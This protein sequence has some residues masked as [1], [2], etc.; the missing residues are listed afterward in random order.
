MPRCQA[1]IQ[2]IDLSDI[3]KALAEKDLAFFIR[4]FWKYID[5]ADYVGGWHIQAICEHLEAVTSGDITRL[6]IT[7]P[8]RHMKS[9]AVSVAWPAWVWIQHPK[10][11]F[12]S[13]SYAQSL[14]I[15]DAVKS[16][17]I[18]D[19]QLY[20]EW[21]GD[22]YKLTSDQNTKIKYE[23]D[24]KG[25][26][27]ATSVG[28][29]T[30][31]DGGDIII[32]DDPHNV[33]DT[34][35]DLKRSSALEWWDTAMSTRLNDART[36]A[37]VI[38]AQRVHYNDLIGHIIESEQGGWI[39]LNLPAEYEP[40]RSCVTV[41]DWKDPRQTEGELLW[42]E[43]FGR[44][45]ID[46]L[47]EQLGTY[48]ASAQLQQ[49]PTPQGGG[50]IQASWFRY[51]KEKPFT[52]QSIQVWDTAFKAKETSDYSVCQTWLL[53]EFG[54]VL[55]DLYR[56]RLPYPDLKRMAT[57]LYNREHPDMVIIEDAASG[58]SLIQDFRN[59]TM[60]VMAVTPD[61]DKVSRAT[62]VTP[63]IESGKVYLREGAPWIPAFLDE[64]I[65]FPRGEFD[66][67]VDVMVHALTYLRRCNIGMDN[68]QG[69]ASIAAG[70]DW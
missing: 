29:S 57:S 21:Y 10:K 55:W 16:R 7:M 64:C 4:R 18:I 3:E 68:I 54:F 28:G 17:R 2:P 38:V 13:A 56:G 31:G 61:K 47:K 32:I 5:P 9:I 8:P 6:I 34:G 40:S 53:T 51:I 43:R 35:S 20:Q 65:Q 59:T 45:H 49:R 44:K 69:A 12:L 24:K 23:N 25:H 30:T 22:R 48:G 19:S 41:L 66:D 62:A 58:Q 50:T 26:R 14:S 36:G 46:E 27:I 70:G 33:M 52:L 67:Q 11:Q 39:H 60:P 42:P 1:Q 37:K 63:T 15:R